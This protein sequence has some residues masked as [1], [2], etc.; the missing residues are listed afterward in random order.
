MVVGCLI[1]LSESI[2]LIQPLLASLTVPETY[3]ATI[4]DTQRVAKYSVESLPP[5]EVFRPP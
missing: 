3:P 4:R 2:K 1:D 5:A